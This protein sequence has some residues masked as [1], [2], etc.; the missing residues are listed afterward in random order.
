LFELE[1][2]SNPVNALVGESGRLKFADFSLTAR[3]DEDL[4]KP[5]LLLADRVYLRSHRLDLIRNEERDISS[6]DKLAPIYAAIS[7]ASLSEDTR[8]LRALGLTKAA[9]LSEADL[10]RY[11]LQ[12]EVERTRADKNKLKFRSTDRAR[13]LADKERER[14]ERDKDEAVWDEFDEKVEP[15]R[16]AL[17]NRFREIK[18]SFESAALSKIAESG[19]LVQEPWDALPKSRPRELLDHEEGPNTEYERAFFSMADEVSK[20]RKS[21]MLADEVHSSL[22]KAEPGVRDSASAHVVG[23]A[24][25]LMRMVEGVSSMP[26]DEILDV[27][28]E[29]ADYLRPFRSFVLDVSAHTDLNGASDAERARLMQIAWE[30]EVEPAIAEMRAHVRS[31][32][33]MSNAIDVF[34]SGEA[35]LQALGVAIGV[36]TTA[37]FV[38]LSTMAAAVAVAPPLLKALWASTREAQSAKQNRAYFVHAMGKRDPQRRAKS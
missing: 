2:F 14:Q 8:L 32:S 36:A 5:A 38:G 12:F 10:A 20:T 37:G 29:L 17:Q 26:I 16:R 30:R 23:G 1:V 11:E 13:Y 25:D 15:F 9:L 33:F 24:V 21:V 27:R 4:V 31:A 6:M 7:A 35:K 22:L 18:T 28:A 19:V 3:Y 34:A